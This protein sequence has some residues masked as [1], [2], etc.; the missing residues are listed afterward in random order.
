MGGII[1]EAQ[2]QPLFTSTDIYVY[3]GKGKDSQNRTALQDLT[4][5][6]VLHETLHNLS[7]MDDPSLYYALTC[8]TAIFPNGMGCRR[9]TGSNTD[10]INAMLVQY[11]CALQ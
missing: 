6:T 11:G 8:A 4:Q 1:A 9:L 2:I 5:S 7:G 10:V 3:T